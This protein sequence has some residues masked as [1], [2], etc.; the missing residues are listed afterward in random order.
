[1][2]S[3]CCTTVLPEPNGDGRRAALGEREERVYYPLAAVERAV[4]DVLFLIRAR[5][6]DGPFLHHRQRGLLPVLPLDDGDRL[7]DG[8]LARLYRADDAGDA[9]GNEDAVLDGG[10]LLHGADDIPSD[11][12]IAYVE[13]G[14]EFPFLIAVERGDEDA[15]GYRMA[16]D[17]AYLLQR[18]LDA[19]VYVLQQAG[20]ELDGKRA[21]RRY[22]LGAGA[23]SARLLIDLYGG[24]VAR[25][26]EYLADKLLF[27]D[28]D[29]VRDVGVHEALSYDQR[30]RDLSYLTTHIC[31]PD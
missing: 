28:A 4:G 6:A 26:V 20:P 11:D 10:R 21:P 30:A 8:E 3:A 24:A 15:A 9:V 13:Q 7:L 29:D 19:V 12:T 18:A 2:A 22:D 27:A 14:L 17:G 25:H 5:H 31:L 1:M 23:E 16:R